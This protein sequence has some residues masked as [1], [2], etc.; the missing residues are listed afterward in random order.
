MLYFDR[1]SLESKAVQVHDVLPAG[2]PVWT[3]GDVRPAPSVAVDGRLAPAGAERFYFSGR[4][5]GT[6][7]IECRRCL[8]EVEREVEADVHVLFAPSGDVAVEGDPDVYEYDPAERDLDLRPAIRE[9]WLLEVPQFVVCSET[10]RGLCP[11]CGTDLN[12]GGCEC[13]GL[14]ADPRW[15]TLRQLRTPDQ[16]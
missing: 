6:A 13:T 14:E 8:V 4:V 12:S 3:G 7:V 5:A 15:E 2:D 11:R 9:A 1:R 16:P 10:C